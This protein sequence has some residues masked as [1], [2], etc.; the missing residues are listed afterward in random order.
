MIVVQLVVATGVMRRI[1]DG[2]EDKRKKIALVI[3]NL[4]LF[5]GTLIAFEIKH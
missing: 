2:N 4:I 1:N 5:F 3:S